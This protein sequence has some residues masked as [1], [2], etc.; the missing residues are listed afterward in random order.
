MESISPRRSN[1]PAT[2]SRV[3]RI[4]G[5]EYC[6]NVTSSHEPSSSRLLPPCSSE[7]KFAQT[8]HDEHGQSG[9]TSAAT[10]LDQRPK[11]VRSPLADDVFH[12]LAVDVGETEVAAGVVVGELFVIESHEVEDGG[13]EVVDVGLVF[14]GLVAVFVGG[15]VA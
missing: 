7:R 8:S 4:E 6:S 5:I 2:I 12:H 1:P 3:S 10:N 13:V 9:I 11:F 15:S 14:D